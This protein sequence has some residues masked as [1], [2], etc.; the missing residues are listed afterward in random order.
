LPTVELILVIE[1]YVLMIKDGHSVTHCS[2][3]SVLKIP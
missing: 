1:D 3:I 2:L